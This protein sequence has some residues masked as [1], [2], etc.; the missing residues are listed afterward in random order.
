MIS[1]ANTLTIV[2]RGLNGDVVCRID[3]DLTWTTM[4]VKEI[5]RRCIN[6]CPCRQSLLEVSGGW[7]RDSDT[8]SQFAQSGVVEISLVMQQPLECC[9]RH[10]YIGLNQLGF[11][12]RSLRDAGFSPVS[13]KNEGFGVWQLRNAGLDD[14]HTLACAGFTAHQLLRGGVDAQEVS[15]AVPWFNMAEERELCR[16]AIGAK[17]FRK[18]RGF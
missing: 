6:A 15:E 2:V 3:G 7:L 8:L 16:S 11:D 14:V 12:A 4:V 13:L 10:T 9:V 1:N 18:F 17:E 5:V